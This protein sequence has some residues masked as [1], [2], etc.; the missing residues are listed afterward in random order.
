V[1]TEGDDGRLVF[2]GGLHR[3]G[4][5]VLARLLDD[6][7]RISGLRGTGMPEDE[8]EHLQSVYPDC[9]EYGG[10]GRFGYAPQL[11]LTEDS[12]LV[13]DDARATLLREWGRW[14]DRDAALLV[15]KSPPNLLKMRFLQAL[16]PQARFILVTRH[17][18]AV[19][20]ATLK[21][22]TRV[23]R[24]WEP[25]RLM[26]HWIHCHRIAFA[27]ASRIRRLHVLRYEHLVADPARTLAGLSTFLDLDPPLVAD[28]IE[29]A[30]SDAYFGAW[31]ED[32]RRPVRGLYLRSI[33]RRHAA[34][35]EE[36]GYA[37]GSPEPLAAPDV[38]T[39]RR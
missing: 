3:S 9:W 10:V 34:A 16:F 7:P 11:H 27:D 21:W 15:E 24:R 19:V 36:L 4:T 25:H 22:R 33:E 35:L 31:A 2:I 23:T 29:P 14:W 28:R 39:A 18:I 30:R 12:P 38:P 6:H 26:D 17:P 20:G 1:G 8:G 32:R 5:T 13:S 37:F